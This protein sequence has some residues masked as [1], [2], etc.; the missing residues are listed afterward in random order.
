MSDGC[1]VSSVGIYWKSNQHVLW[2]M[3]TVVI[4]LAVMTNA[5]HHQYL[6]ARK[7]SIER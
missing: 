1:K 2:F 6:P 5:S 3:Y 7:D 4:C